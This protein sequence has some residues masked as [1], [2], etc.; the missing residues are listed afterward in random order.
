MYFVSH[1]YDLNVKEKSC[2]E[3]LITGTNLFSVLEDVEAITEEAV[4]LYIL[5]YETL[6][7]EKNS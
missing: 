5:V 1:V 7:L 6:S 3:I 4:V 2:F